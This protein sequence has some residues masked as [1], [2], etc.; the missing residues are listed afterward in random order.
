MVSEVEMLL[1]FSL[2]NA[3]LCIGY[4]QHSFHFKDIQVKNGFLS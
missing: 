3:I 2:E 4:W 1:F